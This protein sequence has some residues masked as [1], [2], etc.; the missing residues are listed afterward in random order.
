MKHFSALTRRGQRAR[1]RRL[2]ESVLPEYR[3][4]NPRLT[5]IA[6]GFNTTFCI[7]A[8]GST[9]GIPR[10]PYAPNRY[11][12]RVHRPGWHG[13]TEQTRVVVSSELRWLSAL[14]RETDLV[15][16]EPVQTLA[17]TYTAVGR[18]AGVPDPHV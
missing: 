10:P 2:A 7:H 1:L 5:P 16:P 4:V 14:C 6:C 12:L 18:D 8:E 15:I 17:E 11:L 13:D 3:L 9:L